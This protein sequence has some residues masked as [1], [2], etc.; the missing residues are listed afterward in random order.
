M[1]LKVK[2]AYG[3]IG[4]VQKISY[5]KKTICKCRKEMR[6]KYIEILKIVFFWTPNFA[7]Q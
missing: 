2:S 3:N 7:M 4:I 1:I 5:I 6:R